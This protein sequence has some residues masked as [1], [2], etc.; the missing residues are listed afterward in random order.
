MDTNNIGDRD[1]KFGSFDG[2]PTG[3]TNDVTFVEII[4]AAQ[5]NFFPL[6]PYHLTGFTNFVT[7]LH[8]HALTPGESS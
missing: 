2:G 8:P 1:V 7:V 5:S 6:K 3:E 4:F